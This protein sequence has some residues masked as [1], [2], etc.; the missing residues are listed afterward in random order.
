MILIAIPAPSMAFDATGMS[1]SMGGQGKGDVI[2]YDDLDHNVHWNSIGTFGR[3]YLK[4]MFI[5][6]I[7]S[8]LDFGYMK[9]TPKG[10]N[11]DNTVD[12]FSL[13]GRLMLHKE[14]TTKI[15]FGF[16]LGL[17]FLSDKSDTYK[18]TEDG[19]YGLITGRI[20]LSVKTG[21]CHSSTFFDEIFCPSFSEYGIDLE[22][23]HISSVFGQDP[24]V[25]IWKIRAYIMF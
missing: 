10:S 20:R 4:D 22:A 25:N 16:G 17:A 5:D 6:Y 19:L 2:G 13:E 21:R 15:A 8:E 18:L 1:V 11:T 24:G 23:D 9:W 12:T 14:V 7:D 3:S